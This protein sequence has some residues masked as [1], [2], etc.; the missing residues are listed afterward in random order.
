MNPVLLFPPAVKI[1]PSMRWAAPEQKM[2]TPV[3]TFALVWPPVAGSQ[4]VARV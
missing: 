1:L 2:F 3:V 4:T